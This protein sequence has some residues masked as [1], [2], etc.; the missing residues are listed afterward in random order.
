MS[1]CDRAEDGLPAR[2]PGEHDAD[3]VRM[4]L[5]DLFE[6]LGAVHHRHPHIADDGVISLLVECLQ[7]GRATLDKLHVP[8]LAHAMQSASQ[9]AEHHGL[10]IYKKKAPEHLDSPSEFR[11]G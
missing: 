6:E 7:G 8:L 2:L 5:L 11:W 9:A 1:R 4:A 3:H 10:V